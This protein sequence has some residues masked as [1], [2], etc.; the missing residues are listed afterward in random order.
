MKI[1]FYI[2]GYI[3]Y[4][5]SFLFPRSKRKFA[6]GSFRGAFNDNA[7][8]LF[9]YANQHCKG[10]NIAWISINRATVAK[11]RELGF[12]AYFFLSPKGIWHALTAKYWFF[13]SYTNDI[14]HCLSGGATCINLWH[15]V[16]LKRIEY[17]ILSGP[18]AKLYDRSDF[19]K[20]F[21]H[22][23]VFRKPDY[24]I[25]SSQSQTQM[26]SSA[27]RI[28]EDRCWELGYPRNSILKQTN[29]ERRKFIE[30]FEPKAMSE[31][32]ARM[33]SYSRVLI[34]MPTW[35]DSQR[36]LFSQSMDLPRLNDVL[37]D[38]NELLLMKPHANVMVGQMA[39]E[40]SNILFLDG[41][42]DVYPLLPYTDVLIT[43]YSSVLYDYLLMPGKDV[44]LYLYDYEDYIRERDLYFPFDENVAGCRVYDF[45]QLL[46]CISRHDYSL[47]DEDRC[48]IVEKFWGASQ[49]YDSCRQILDRVIN[50]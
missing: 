9:I 42:L 39:Q 16:A 34:Y 6:F 21:T 10:F 7:K 32:I 26:F 4:P 12:K 15:G 45:E 23:Q 20:V 49:H 25:T 19:Y 30:A 14:N 50:L 17:L 40:F 24:L 1:L 36:N 33:Q 44:I 41:R 31:L 47:P 8:Y 11:V 35:R 46:T 2:I 28:P 43:D 29:D 38:N 3:V 5:F 22:P 48:R 18:L 27:F 37:M 13:N